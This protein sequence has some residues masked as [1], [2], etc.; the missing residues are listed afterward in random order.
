MRPAKQPL[1]LMCERHGFLNPTNTESRCLL[2]KSKVEQ[3]VKR[4]GKA[5]Q[6]SGWS[7]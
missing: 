2:N 6:L 3:A 1:Q 4:F 5:V 7:V